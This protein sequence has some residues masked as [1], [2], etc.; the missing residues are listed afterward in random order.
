MECYK[1][2]L[3]SIYDDVLKQYI[4]DELVS[5]L[6]IDIKREVT[7][8]DIGN[9]SCVVY[10][11]DSQSWG[12]QFATNIDTKYDLITIFGSFPLDD[13]KYDFLR[14]CNKVV[15]DSGRVVLNFEHGTF[16]DGFDGIKDFIECVRECNLVV[17]SYKESLEEDVTRFVLKKNFGQGHCANV[18]QYIY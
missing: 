10:G 15:N 11:V 12:L 2:K 6:D 16:A 1:D 7:S 3:E 4:Q 13:K 17:E 18:R 5:I 9:I 8:G 14:A